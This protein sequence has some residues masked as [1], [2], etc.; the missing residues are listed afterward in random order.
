[1]EEA[2]WPI[3]KFIRRLGAG[4]FAT[5]RQRGCKRSTLTSSMRA[6]VIVGT[7]GHWS[8]ILLVQQLQRKDSRR[9]AQNITNDV[10]P[11]TK[12]GSKGESQ[13]NRKR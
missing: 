12:H 13:R 5:E 11:E 2:S 1:M 10:I 7:C 3:E 9:I 6:R 4:G 8:L